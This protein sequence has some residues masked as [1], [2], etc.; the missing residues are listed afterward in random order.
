M[1]ID[2]LFIDKAILKTAEIDYLISRLKTDPQWIEDSKT[3]YDLINTSD[4]PVSK[5]KKLYI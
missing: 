5:A 2:T 1:K 4:D 3:V